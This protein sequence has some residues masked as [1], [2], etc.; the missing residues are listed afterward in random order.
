MQAMTVSKK[1][2]VG[3]PPTGAAMTPAEKQRA[4][5][6]RRAAAQAEKAREIEKLREQLHLEHLKNAE[7]MSQID[8][9]SDKLQ[10]AEAKQNQKKEA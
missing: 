6:Q 1:R 10:A 7:L 3:R 2:P 8:Q 5:R 9:L 4:Y